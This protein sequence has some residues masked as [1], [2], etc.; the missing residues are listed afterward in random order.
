M[1]A[2]A[3]RAS[4]ER[5]RDDAQALRSRY[6]GLRGCVG[7]VLCQWAVTIECPDTRADDCPSGSAAQRESNHSRE[8]RRDASI[9]QRLHAPVAHAENNTGGRRQGGTGG[10]PNKEGDEKNRESPA[11]K[12]KA[13]HGGTRGSWLRAWAV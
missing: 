7:F 11:G 3:A 10:C 6:Q 8:N 4:E 12:V 5:R 1:W 13:S 9:K 2:D